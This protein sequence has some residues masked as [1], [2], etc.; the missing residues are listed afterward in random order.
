ML[1]ITGICCQI[2]SFN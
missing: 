1:H 2:W